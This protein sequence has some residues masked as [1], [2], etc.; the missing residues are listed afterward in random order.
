MR[1]PTDAEKI[2][3]LRAEIRRLQNALLDREV[4]HVEELIE[5]EYSARATIAHERRAWQ[6]YY[7]MARD[8]DCYFHSTRH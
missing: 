4:A 7:A 5:A 3:S 2:K 6:T 8:G 1:K